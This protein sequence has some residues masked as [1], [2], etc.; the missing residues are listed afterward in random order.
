MP[1]ISAGELEKF[2]YCPL[3]WKLS[4]SESMDATTMEGSVR[5]HR[6]AGELETA[7]KIQETSCIGAKGFSAADF[8]HGPIAMVRPN[9]PA[10][11]FAP[12]GAATGGLLETA[13][14]VKERGGELIVFTDDPA[15]LNLGRTSFALPPVSELFSPFTCI[16]AAQLF[17]CHLALAKGLD[18]D[19]PRGLTKV[20][21]TR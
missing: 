2:C 12:T 21:V 14:K 7:L 8:V 16:A 13:A 3:S 11:L 19:R 18:P 9:F 20:T 5:H 15:I 17:A 1:G 6:M 10:L 4:G